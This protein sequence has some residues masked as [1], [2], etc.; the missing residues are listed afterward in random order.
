MRPL[1]NS[2]SHGVQSLSL[3]EIFVTLSHCAAA[4][5]SGQQVQSPLVEYG[6]ALVTQGRPVQRQ[7]LQVALERNPVN[8]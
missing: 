1:V 7:A 3:A 2:N 4:R 8:I 5:T 6:E